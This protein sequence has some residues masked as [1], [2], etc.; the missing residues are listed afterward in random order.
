L[1]P[2]QRSLRAMA[3]ALPEDARRHNRSLVLQWLFRHGPTSRADLARATH[4]TRVTISDLVA[5]LL[6]DGLVEEVG[7]RAEPSVGKPATLV[8]IVPDARHVICLDLSDDERFTGA[9][10]NLAGK[11]LVRRSQPRRGRTGDAASDV[12]VDLA[13]E[14]A[15]ETTQPVLG[16]GVGSPGLVGAAGVVLESDNLRWFELPLGRRVTERL[17]VP[18]HVV[19]DANAATL[20]EYTFGEAAGRSLLVVKIGQGVG[21][22]LLIDGRLYVGDGYAAGEIGHVVVDERG[23]RCACGRRGCLER[24]VAAPFLRR[25]LAAAGSP[26]AKARVLRAAGRRLGVALATVV[27]ALNLSEVILSGPVDVLSEPF[28]SAALD[29]IRMRTMP[30]VGDHVDVRYSALDEDDVLLGA[31]VLVLSQE[32][33][34]A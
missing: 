4:L 1:P 2:Q 19:N 6:S 16:V 34:V 26:A 17:G 9:L 14:L 22:G 20:G 29:T 10:V 18:T 13:A 24:A 25:R 5:E 23:E 7:R 31:A 32:L 11:V 33:G 3:K 15:A 12:A 30:A 28:R 8:G 21:A 27:S